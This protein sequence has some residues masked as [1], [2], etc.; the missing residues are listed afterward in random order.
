MQG[1]IGKN[2]PSVDCMVPTTQIKTKFDGCEL[3]CAF[4]G[5]KLIRKM[6]S[7][8]FALEQRK[9]FPK[10]SLA[11]TREGPVLFEQHHRT[12]FGQ[13]AIELPGSSR[14]PADG[15]AVPR[16]RNEAGC[17]IRGI[18]LPSVGTLFQSSLFER[19]IDKRY[20]R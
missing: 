2:G 16:M 20:F 6:D 1:E 19:Q 13:I 17:F 4:A 5:T 18:A 11:G 9:N 14:V 15:R 12:V 8:R 10:L 7:A 3:F